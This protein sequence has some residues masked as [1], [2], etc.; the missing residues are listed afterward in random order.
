MTPTAGVIR[1][2][3][4]VAFGL[5]DQPPVLVR[6]GP[7]GKAKVL[8]CGGRDYHDDKR[9]WAV[10]DLMNDAVGISVVITGAA[11]GADLNAEDWARDRQIDYRAYPAR[12]TEEAAGPKRNARMLA[13]EHAPDKGRHLGVC[14]AFPGGKGTA[15]MVGR[16]EAAGVPVI[17]VD[18]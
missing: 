1:T 17:R 7:G 16:C 3:S 11:R 2:A 14:L 15:D 5:A 13:T 4:G 8:V 10:L 18:W 6:T 9:I 12:W